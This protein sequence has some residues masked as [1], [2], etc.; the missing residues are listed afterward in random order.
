MGEPNYSKFGGNIEPSST[1]P[2][3]VL[4]VRYVCSFRNW[5]SPNFKIE[6]ISTIFDY[7]TPIENREEWAKCLSQNEAQL[8]SL[9]VEVLGFR[10]VHPFCSDNLSERL[11]S[12]IES[13]F[14]NL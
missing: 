8:S 6:K 10:Q 7:L 1:L 4:R 2:K 3:F 9:K 13:K 14:R 12:T 11:V 5:S